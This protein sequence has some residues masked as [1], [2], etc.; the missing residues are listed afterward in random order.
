MLH[1][2]EDSGSSEAL[3]IISLIFV[4]TT[5]VLIA[6]ALVNHLVRHESELALA[7]T[8]RRDDDL[9]EK[10]KRRVARA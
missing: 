3:A 4:C 5:D 8:W 10:Y 7:A 2:A 9:A 1:K 6:G